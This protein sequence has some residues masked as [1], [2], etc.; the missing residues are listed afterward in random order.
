LTVFK[1]EK[2]AS[3]RYYVEKGSKISKALF[4]IAVYSFCE[5]S[6]TN[7]ERCPEVLIL[8][9]YVKLRWILGEQVLGMWIG[10]IGLRIGT[11]GGLL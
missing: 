8:E 10:F 6:K 9:L 3:H 7:Q 4:T 2:A 1:V 11:G 5:K